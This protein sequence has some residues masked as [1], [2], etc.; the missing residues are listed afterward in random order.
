MEQH[1]SELSVPDFALYKAM[2]GLAQSSERH[3]GLRQ[4]RFTPTPHIFAR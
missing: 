4:R 2:Q 1:L 3:P